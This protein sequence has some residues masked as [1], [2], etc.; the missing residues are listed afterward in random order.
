MFRARIL[1][2]V[3]ALAAGLFV[4]TASVDAHPPVKKVFIHEPHRV[5]LA[6]RIVPVC[7]ASVVVA[8]VSVYQVV[9][10][11]NCNQPWATYQSYNSFTFA[12]DMAGQLGQQGY[13]T[14]IW[15]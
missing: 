10:R 15:Q 12:Q 6:Q 11:A 13:E 4:T 5:I 3:L 8:P 9:Y 7:R 14:A 1:I 2:P